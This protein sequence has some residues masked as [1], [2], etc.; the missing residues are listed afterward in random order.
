MIVVDLIIAVLLGYALFKGVKNGLVVS[1]VSFV[2]LIA[3]IYLS[4]RFSF[5]VRGFLTIHTQWNPETLTVV[6]FMLTFVIVLV[7]LFFLGRALTKIAESLA[8]GFVNK[9]FGAVFEGLKMLL[10][11]SVF[12]NVFQKINYNNL[13]VPEEKLDTSVFYKPIEKVA[14][15]IF[16]LMEQWY[17]LALTETMDQIKNIDIQQKN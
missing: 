2:A 17:Q 3:G 7:S 8:L 16:P 11:I 13:I 15:Y 9:L 12:L 10:I 4:L 14:Q 5:Y 6:A 1:V